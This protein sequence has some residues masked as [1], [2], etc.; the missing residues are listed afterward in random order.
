[1]LFVCIEIENNVNKAVVKMSVA[2]K[3]LLKQRE[4]QLPWLS[5]MYDSELTS[6]I[7]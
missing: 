3:A 2:L 7:Q 5:V 4:V 6:K 1:M